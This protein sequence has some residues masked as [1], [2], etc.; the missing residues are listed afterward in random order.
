[1]A[2]PPVR[3]RLHD[4]RARSGPGRLDDVLHRRR[5]GH[6]VV[7]IDG[8]E[9]HPVAGRPPFEG[10]RVLGRRG[11]EFGV[12]VVLAEVD[13]RQSVDRGQVDRLV[14]GTLGHRAVPEER[15][16]DAAIVSQLRGGG[17]TRGDGQPG[18]HDPVGAEDADGRVGDVHRAP[19]PAVGALRLGH[20]LREHA[21][22][23]QALGQA[24][25]VAAMRRGD[26]VGGLERPTCAHRRRLLPG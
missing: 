15:H 8:D 4:G 17:R 25:P 11:R 16:R 6:D 14:E 7:A 12:A 9:G 1:M 13:H 3:C 5:R 26:H 19:A 20:Q 10:C 21:E 18:R 24:M 23:V 2:V 22:G